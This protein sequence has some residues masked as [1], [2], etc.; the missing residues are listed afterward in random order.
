M[1]KL[2]LATLL[3]LREKLETNY[4]NM[5]DDMFSKFKNKQGLFKGLRKTYTAYEGF[6]DSPE[7]RTFNP[8]ASTVDDQFDWLKQYTKD[9]F[10][11]TF[12]IE[13]AN[14]LG[15]KAK[16]VVGGQDFGE[17]YTTELLRLKTILEGKLKDILQTIPTRSEQELWK[18][19]ADH[20]FEV[21]G[22]VFC[23]DLL[24]EKAST[25]IKESYIL[26]DPHADKSRSPMIG[27]K[28]TKVNI[29][30]GT[31]QNF[32]GEW[33]LRQRAEFIAKYNELHKAV[34]VALEEANAVEIK[35]P[36]DLGQKV[37]AYLF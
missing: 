16:L 33:S 25:T 18:E 17:Y 4:K 30:E 22:K 8:L 27:E 21:K 6:A 3:G 10:D 2:K 28:S 26:V 12:T 32:S 37:L 36:S 19:I 23:T 13:R 14:A 24:A 34:I 35:E 9:F 1:A 15:A 31:T 29:G 11:C 7:K 5:L 20:P